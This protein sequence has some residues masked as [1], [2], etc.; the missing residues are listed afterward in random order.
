M[1]IFW[2]DGIVPQKL[3]QCIWNVSNKDNS[4]GPILYYRPNNSEE[5]PFHF[6]EKSEEMNYR[7]FPPKVSFEVDREGPRRPPLKCETT[8]S[9]PNKLFPKTFPQ[10]SG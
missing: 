3:E 10:Q 9:S 6:T 7:R 2:E 8:L 1:P 4:R 5:H